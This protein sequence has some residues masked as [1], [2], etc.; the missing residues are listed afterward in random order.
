MWFTKIELKDFGAFYGKHVLDMQPKDGKNITLITGSNGGGRTQFCQAIKW[1]LYGYDPSIQNE[2]K[3]LF[4]WKHI[5]RTNRRPANTMLQEPLIHDM[6]VRLWLKEESDGKTKNYFVERKVVYN[7]IKTFFK[8]TVDNKLC[9][10]PLEVVGTLF[11]LSLSHLTFLT[12][13]DIRNLTR[14]MGSLKEIIE[15][16]RVS[17]I[18]NIDLIK[19]E[20]K[21]IFRRLTIKPIEINKVYIDNNLELSLIYNN[22]IVKPTIFGTSDQSILC[23][24]L[25]YGFL[26]THRRD[27]P[28]IIDGLPHLDLPYDKKVLSVIPQFADQIILTMTNMGYNKAQN[29]ATK[30]FFNHV[31]NCYRLERNELSGNR[32]ILR[33]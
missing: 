15:R 32:K 2:S 4:T 30:D 33:C 6:Y 19:A 26:K 8:V 17:N 13:D 29:E 11:P 10:K 20:A 31:A 28:L 18:N 12:G 3:K 23:L 1:C 7:Q 21:N 22:E 24:S 5:N 25:I 27:I 14:A 9:P 16:T